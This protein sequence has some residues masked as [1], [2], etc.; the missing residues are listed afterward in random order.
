MLKSKKKRK[1]RTFSA[2]FLI[3]SFENELIL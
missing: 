1:K 2:C 3:F